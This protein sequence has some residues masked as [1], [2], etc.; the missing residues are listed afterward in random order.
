MWYWIM[1]R[2]REFLNF[3]DEVSKDSLKSYLLFEK[4]YVVWFK[5]Y[6]IL[7]KIKSYR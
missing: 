3:Y 6:D 7:E 1:R 2:Y 4:L 5:L